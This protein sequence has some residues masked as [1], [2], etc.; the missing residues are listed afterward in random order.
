LQVLR[1]LRSRTQPRKLG[2]CY[3]ILSTSNWIT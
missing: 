3:E 2:S 1:L